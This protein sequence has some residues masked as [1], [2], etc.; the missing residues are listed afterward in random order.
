M[1][2][3]ISASG[4]PGQVN[5]SVAAQLTAAGTSNPEAWPTLVATRDYIASHVTKAGESD[6]VA[7]TAMIAVEI[8]IAPSVATPS[9]GAPVAEPEEP[10]GN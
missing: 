7:V 3:E 5:A 10:D 4:T 2:I 8:A 9:T 6:S 1:Q